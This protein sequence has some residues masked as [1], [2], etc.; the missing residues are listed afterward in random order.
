MDREIGVVHIGP[1]GGEALG[2]PA[3][4]FVEAGVHQL[5][6]ATKDLTPG[7]VDGGPDILA[8]GERKSLIALAVVVGA[9]VEAAMVLVVE[10]LDDFAGRGFG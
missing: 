4:A 6:P 1:G 10:P 3:A 2:L 8:D 5:T 7:L 9:D